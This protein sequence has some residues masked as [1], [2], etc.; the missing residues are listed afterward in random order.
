M[1]PLMVPCI[2]NAIWKIKTNCETLLLSAKDRPQNLRFK[3]L[4]QL[5]EC[6][7][8]T[9]AR[10]RGS[11]FIYKVPGYPKVMNFQELPDGKA[12]PYQVKELLK[13][14]EDISKEGAS[15]GRSDE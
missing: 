5:A 14:I 4:C 8:F 1:V 9:L 12:K 3:E 6:Y 7:G 13:A 10:Q 11:H 2:C 15:G